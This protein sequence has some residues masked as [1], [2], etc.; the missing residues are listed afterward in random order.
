MRFKTLFTLLAIGLILPTSTW[1]QK[2]LPSEKELKKKNYQQ[3]RLGPPPSYDE[4]DTNVIVEALPMY[5]DGLQGLYKFIGKET[6]YPKKARKEKIEGLVVASFTVM[7][8]GS[9]D[10]IKIEKGAHELLDEEAMRVLGEMD[11]WYPGT[12]RGKPVRVMMR[13]PFNFK[14]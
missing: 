14:L 1:A 10:E 12:Q 13:I 3:V 9:V 7:P 5:P 11:Q 6:K 8:D 4:S 2:E